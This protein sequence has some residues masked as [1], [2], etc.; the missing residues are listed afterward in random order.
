MDKGSIWIN[1]KKQRINKFIIGYMINWGL[2]FNKT[3]REQVEKCMYTTFGV[4]TQPF[5]KSTLAKK[6]KCVSI[7]NVLWDNSR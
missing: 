6:Y 5:I 3:F 2:N 7:N 4:I 1:E